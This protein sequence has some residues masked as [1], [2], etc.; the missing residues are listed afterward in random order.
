VAVNA[1]QASSRQD[2]RNILCDSA[3][4]R[5]G[6]R[7]VPD[8]DPQA[9]RES[10]IHFLKESAPWGVEVVIK[11]ESCGNWWHTP[12]DHPAFGAAFSA[13]KKGY[14]HEAV[15]IGC[16]GS[17]PFVEPLSRELGGIPAL[18]IGV[19]DPYSNAHAENESL[20]LGDW[21][22]A[23]RSAIHLYAELADVLKKSS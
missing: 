21:E 20:H 17:I 18:L 16:G 12:A 6:I 7:I 19:E 22:K 4:A 1:I 2:A 23:I 11:P 13:L 8:M 9:V 10:L 14:G 15:A 3:W 5:I